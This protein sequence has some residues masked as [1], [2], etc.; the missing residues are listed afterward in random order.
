MADRCVSERPLRSIDAQR[1]DRIDAGHS[2]CRETARGERHQPTISAE[3]HTKVSRVAC[4]N[5]EHSARMPRPASAATRTNAVTTDMLNAAARPSRQSCARPARR[6]TRR[7]SRGDGK[8]RATSETCGLH[9]GDRERHR[10]QTG[11]V[12]LEAAT[13]SGSMVVLIAR[14]NARSDRGTRWC[15]DCR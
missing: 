7:E 6:V 9:A 1:H 11:E 4:R 3:T 15:G 10:Q 8:R 12:C 14:R 2:S 5:L 13:G